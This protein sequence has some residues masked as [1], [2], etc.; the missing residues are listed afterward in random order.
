MY[1]KADGNAVVANTQGQ[2][3]D[4]VRIV[5]TTGTTIRVQSYMVVGSSVIDTSNAQGVD[6]ENTKAGRVPNGQIDAQ[7]ISQDAIKGL[8]K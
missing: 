8:A 5:S 2:F 1:T 4:R 3:G 6:F 7:P